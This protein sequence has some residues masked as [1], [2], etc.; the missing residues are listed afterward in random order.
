[1]LPRDDG[2]PEPGRGGGGIVVG[3]SRGPGGGGIADV[4]A[5][6]DERFDEYGL[7]GADGPVDRLRPAPCSPPD[8][9]GRNVGVEGREEEEEADE[10]MEIVLEP[11]ESRDCGRLRPLPLEGITE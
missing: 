10:G 11:P 3:R 6:S 4:L 7:F 9:I 2:V 8:G 5:P 1:M